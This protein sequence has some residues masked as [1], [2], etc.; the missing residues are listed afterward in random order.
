MKHELILSMAP[1]KAD[2]GKK[3]SNKVKA[4]CSRC[5]QEMLQTTIKTHMNNLKCNFTHEFNKMESMLAREKIKK[6]S[7]KKTKTTNDCKKETNKKQKSVE[8]NLNTESQNSNIISHDSF[9]ED[10][11]LDIS[12]SCYIYNSDLQIGANLASVFEDHNIL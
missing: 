11:L 1:K 3:V 9:F 4:R 7:R 6:F 10:L 12:E 8:E 5:G 2:K